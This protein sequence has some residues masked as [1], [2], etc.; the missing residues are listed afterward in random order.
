M[1][2][3]GYW[4][5]R[6]SCAALLQNHEIIIRDHKIINTVPN[7][8]HAYIVDIAFFGVFVVPKHTKNMCANLTWT[9][10]Y[11]NIST[12]I[13]GSSAS[14]WGVPAWFRITLLSMIRLCHLTNLDAMFQDTTPVVT[15][16]GAA[17]PRCFIYT[18][19]VGDLQSVWNLPLTF[20]YG[21]CYNY[22]DINRYSP[23]N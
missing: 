20:Q 6:R 9:F 22:I 15:G 16:H 19:Y 2:P 18:L 3:R 5:P 8:S 23:R 7:Q 12:P 17:V 11:Q 1:I 14:L 10:S 21:H 4:A 13:S